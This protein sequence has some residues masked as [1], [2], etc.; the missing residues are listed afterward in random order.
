LFL[1]SQWLSEVEHFGEEA[2]Y[3]SLRWMSMERE[4]RWFWPQRCL[5]TGC[6][7]HLYG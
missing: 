7:G 1:W 6:F 5:T 3:V 4:C 2:E